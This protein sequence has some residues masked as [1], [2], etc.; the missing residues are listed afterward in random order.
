MRKWIAGL[1]AAV[2]AFGIPFSAFAQNIKFT[3]VADGAYYRDAVEWAVAEGITAGTGKG[4]FSPDMV[5][6][7][8][9]IVTFLWRAA[10]EPAPSTYEQPFADVPVDAYYYEAVLWAVEEGITSG[11]GQDRFNPNMNCS[12][13]QIA[14]LLW[15]F[16]GEPAAAGRLAFGDVP[17]NSFF[18]NAVQ[19]MVGE[20]ITLGAGGNR[21]GSYNSCTRAQIVTFLY[22]YLDSPAY[23]RLHINEYDGY[24]LVLEEE[25]IADRSRAEVCTAYRNSH[26]EIEIYRQSL[27]GTSVSVY[28]NYS[29]GF[30]SNTA[31]HI[32]DVRTVRGFGGRNYNVTA[33]HRTPL[34]RV[35]NDYNHYVVFD[36][37]EGNY[38]YTVFIKSK[39]PTNNVDFYGYGLLESLS[40]FNPTAKAP[41]MKGASVERDWNQATQAFYDQYFGADAELSWG[42]FNND[43]AWGDFTTLNGYEQELGK[44]FSFMLIYTDFDEDTIERLS[45]MPL[46]AKQNGK[47]AEITLQ[48]VNKASGN[49]VYDILDGDYDDFLRRYAKALANFGE[50]VLFRLFNEMNGDWC[51]YSAYNYSRDTSLYR[52]VWRYIYGIFEEQGANKNVLWVWNP[53]EGS[54]PNF[55]WNHT[56]AYYPG[57][58]YVDIIGLTAYNTG[59]Y[60]SQHGEKWKSFTALYDSLYKNYC[61]RFEQPLMITEFACAEMGG[62]KDA[63]TEAMFQKITDYDRIKVAI[64]WDGTDFDPANGGIARD[65]RIKSVLDV[66][67]K[68]M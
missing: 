37:R 48:T 6:S 50:P 62:N 66:F 4:K 61:N 26:T 57:D 20:G 52:E 42:I 2:I 24:S 13:S 68:Y 27:S 38:V 67:K 65:Y 15:R 12:R 35:E 11:T 9:Q 49:M 23:E 14:A 60:Y 47:V 59:T 53:N 46:R 16:A 10:G 18:Y 55:K 41:Q 21:F 8:A 54:F 32:L 58:E 44:K 43:A 3:D 22:R 63:W 40:F 30:L 36:T 56:M 5:C 39:Y 1:L 28:Q 31:D 33:W 29:N 64:W 25:Y 34:A 45:Y 7:R 17:S 19:W 51:P